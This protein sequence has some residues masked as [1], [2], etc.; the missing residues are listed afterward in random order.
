MGKIEI[1]EMWLKRLLYHIQSLEEGKI[2]LESIKKLKE[3]Y[4]NMN[5]SIED[6]IKLLKSGK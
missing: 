6:Q 3:K 4:E 5:L 1:D 2:N